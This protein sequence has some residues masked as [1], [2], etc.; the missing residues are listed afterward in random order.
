MILNK[1]LNKDVYY[2]TAELVIENGRVVKLDTVGISVFTD[3]DVLR[4]KLKNLLD[5]NYNLIDIS[6][7]EMDDILEHNGIYIQDRHIGDS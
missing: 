4:R 6:P 3:I 7:G 5:R 1:I 2:Q